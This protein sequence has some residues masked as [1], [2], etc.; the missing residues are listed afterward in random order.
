MLNTHISNFLI[1]CKTANF[2]EKSLEALTCRLGEFNDYLK[3]KQIRSVKNIQYSDLL[4]FSA[5]F[6]IPSNHV[7]KSRVWTL[8]RFF[9][10]LKI[11]SIV[12]KNIA[13]ELPSPKIAKTIPKY[14]TITEFNKVLEYFCQNV[15]SSTGHRNLLIIMILGFLGLRLSS[16]L[17][18]NVEDVDINSRLIWIRAK[19]GIYRKMVMPQ[20][21]CEFLLN[22][23]QDLNLKQGPLFLS[24]RKKRISERTLQD[25]FKTAREELKIDKHLHAHLFRHTAATHLNKVAGPEIT[26]YVLGHACRKNTDVYTHLN[27][28]IYAEYMIKHRYHY[29]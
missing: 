20:I 27:P 29:L 18:L 26:Q 21:L 16:V 25:I 5:D 23:I 10:F 7:K 8:K 6:H 19:G 22:Y 28:D 9:G 15:H 2:S 13:I 3:Q 11:N 4:E 1:Y 17:S 24:K 14:L 12:D